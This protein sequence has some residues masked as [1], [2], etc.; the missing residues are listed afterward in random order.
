MQTKIDYDQIRED[1]NLE[2][3]FTDKVLAAFADDWFTSVPWDKVEYAF[4]GDFF[5]SSEDV[6]IGA[7]LCDLYTETGDLDP[8]VQQYID[9]ESFGRDKRLSGHFRAVR[10]ELGGKW[11]VFRTV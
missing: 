8:Y 1:H 5:A 2:E 6:A 10:P 4:V 11:Y 7:S 3:W 9:W